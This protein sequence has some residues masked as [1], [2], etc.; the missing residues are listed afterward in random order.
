MF[1]PSSGRYMLIFLDP[2]KR[3]GV[4]F[5]KSLICHWPLTLIIVR[6]LSLYLPHSSSGPAPFL[7][8]IFIFFD[9]H[10]PKAMPVVWRQL[11]CYTTWSGQRLLLAARKGTMALGW[12]MR[13]QPL[14]GSCSDMGLFRGSWMKRVQSPIGGKLRGKH[15]S[16][17]QPLMFY[18]VSFHSF[19][20]LVSNK[21]QLPIPM[22][23]ATWKVIIYT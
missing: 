12:L 15:C 6:T 13:T 1:V 17:I 7:I 23:M 22:P 18:S 2:V 16:F 14:C 19:P 21:L 4:N 11:M 20:V 5:T 8:D 10:Q 3:C 9:P